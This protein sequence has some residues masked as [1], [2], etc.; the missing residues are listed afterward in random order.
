MEIV[1]SI[2]IHFCI[3]TN[4][5]LPLC[6]NGDF[7]ARIKTGVIYYWVSMQKQGKSGLNW[8]RRNRLVTAYLIHQPHDVI[9]TYT[10]V[11]GTRRKVRLQLMAALQQCQKQMARLANGL[12][13]A[14]YLSLPQSS[15]SYL[16]N[17]ISKF[18][19]V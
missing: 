8:K 1:M 17:Q 5:R 6:K 9:T 11:E 14:S 19:F 15:S 12:S 10:E 18:V 13:L 3:H 7:V 16:L 2:V 4:G